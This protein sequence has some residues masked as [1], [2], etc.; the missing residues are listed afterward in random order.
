MNKLL[1]NPCWKSI[2]AIVAACALALPA[3][4]RS[5]D[6]PQSDPRLQKLYFEEANRW[7]MW[8][9]PDRKQKAVIV[10]E[11]VFRWQNL[12]RANG[13]SGAMFVWLFEGRPVVIGGVFSNPSAPNRRDILHEFHALGPDRLYPDFRDSDSKWLPGAGVTLKPLP[14]SPVVA[15]TTAKRTLQLRAIARDFKAKSTDAEG[16]RWQLRLLP[17]PLYRYEN[18]GGSLIDG[19]LMA[20]VSDAGIDP[21]II[22]ILE[23]RKEADRPTW[24]YRAVR[25]SIADLYLDY[26]GDS[27]WT[28]LREDPAGKL[29]NADNTYGLIRDRAIDEF[30]ALPEK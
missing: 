28:S 14:D 5:D 25:L 19:A 2:L 22:L 18:P 23:A 12:A 27:V 20:L 24:Y 26:K 7:D 8:V 13:Q 29:G 11:P 10:A 4:T 3:Q 30:P 16:Q 21:E 6:I 9:G 15:D 17:K 1:P